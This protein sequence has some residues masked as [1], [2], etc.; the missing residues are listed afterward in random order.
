M[1]QLPPTPADRARLLHLRRHFALMVASEE[2]LE[3]AHRDT[4]ATGA[5]PE[6]DFSALDRAL[7]E[8]K[9]ADAELRALAAAQPATPAA[10][11]A[12]VPFNP[13]TGFAAGA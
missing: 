4:D 11:P 13:W 12:P 1:D 3:L 9:A 8:A 10:A 5:P 7:A 2:A 6:I